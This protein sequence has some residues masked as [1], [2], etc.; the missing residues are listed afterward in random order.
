M[1]KMDP[2]EE[3][4]KMEKI[5]PACNGRRGPHR[6]SGLGYAVPAQAAVATPAGNLT[7]DTIG[8]ETSFQAVGQAI[9]DLAQQKQMANTNTTTIE[10][11][12]YLWEFTQSNSYMPKAKPIK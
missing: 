3:M 11:E 1:E 6:H 7:L 12:G 5:H 9:G 4:D 2:Q 10:R 8:L